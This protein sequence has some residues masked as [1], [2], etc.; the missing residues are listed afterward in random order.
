M[1][2]MN[3]D[4]QKTINGGHYYVIQCKSC[5]AS[6]QNSFLGA[7]AC[8]AHMKRRKHG[9]AYSYHY[10]DVCTAMGVKNCGQNGMCF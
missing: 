8:N 2:K 1:K 3:S 7:L 4:V 6:Y 5:S 10:K 9:A